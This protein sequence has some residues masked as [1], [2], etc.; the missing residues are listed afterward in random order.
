MS[1]SGHKHEPQPADSPVTSLLPQQRDLYGQLSRLSEKQRNFIT[2]NDSERLLALLA[3]RQQLID[4]L[5]AI[6]DEL[7]PHQANWRQFRDSLGEDEGRRVDALVGE[8]KT[9][10]ARILKSDETDT[11]LLSARKGEA[12]RAMGTVRTGR[13]AGRAYAASA[14]HQQG[15]DWAQE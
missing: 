2:G 13:Q 9:L 6:G 11:A 3:E 14:E 15:F 10:L 4:R 7:R 1:V 8:I 12:E 5:Q